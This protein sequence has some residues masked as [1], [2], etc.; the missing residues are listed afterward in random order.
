MTIEP[1]TID[2]APIWFND[3][4]AEGWAQGY[5]A[6]VASG[7]PTMVETILKYSRQIDNGRT[8]RS[9]FKHAEGEMAELDLEITLK[10]TG[11]RS[12]ED[13]VIGEAMDVINCLID[14]V[15]QINPNITEAELVAIQ[16]RK[17]AKWATKYAKGAS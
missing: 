14:L 7:Q 2:D 3:Q 6:A 17:C 9:T 10:A 13:G 16:E 8:V 4:E 12:G 11:L 1:K 15:Y 5:N